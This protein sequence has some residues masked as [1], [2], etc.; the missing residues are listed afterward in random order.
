MLVCV[1][2]AL[3]R[4]FFV[5]IE[6]DGR[7]C[8]FFFEEREDHFLGVG[9]EEYLTGEEAVEL[10]TGDVFGVAL[11]EV[12]GVLLRDGVVHLPETSCCNDGLWYVQMLASVFADCQE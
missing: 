3:Y 4:H 6:A 12:R 2:P 10:A 1:L 8:T 5:V 7:V 11:P 9:H